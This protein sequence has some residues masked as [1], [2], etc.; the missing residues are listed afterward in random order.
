MEWLLR[1]PPK[2]HIQTHLH[3]HEP[4]RRSPLLSLWARGPGDTICIMHM[5]RKRRIVAGF[6]FWGG[7]GVGGGEG[8]VGVVVVAHDML[9]CVCGCLFPCVTDKVTPTSGPAPSAS[10]VRR[11]AAMHVDQNSAPKKRRSKQS[12]NPHIQRE[13]C[14]NGNGGGGWRGGGVHRW[15]AAIRNMPVLFTTPPVKCLFSSE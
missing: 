9:M 12:N 5:N 3:T 15:R 1:C 6:F 14:N 11:L 4:G 13:E 8:R 10:G 2:P 7:G